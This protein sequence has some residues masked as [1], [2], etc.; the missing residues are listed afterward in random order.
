MIRFALSGVF[1]VATLVIIL[2]LAMLYF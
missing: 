1:T 2:V